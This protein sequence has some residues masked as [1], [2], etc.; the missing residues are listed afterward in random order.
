LAQVEIKHPSFIPY[1][2]IWISWPEGG[3]NEVQKLKKDS[4]PLMLVLSFAQMLQYIR[5]P[6]PARSPF[7]WAELLL[8]SEQKC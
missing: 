5:V 7:H 8:K 4:L 2:Y 6:Y 3:K 1:K